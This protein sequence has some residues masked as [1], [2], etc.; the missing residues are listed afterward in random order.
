MGT[1]SFFV[2]ECVELSSYI[3]LIL[4]AHFVRR[5]LKGTSKSI[6]YQWIWNENLV[7]LPKSTS[8]ATPLTL[9]R[10]EE[11]TYFL[12]FQYGTANK[13][14]RLPAPLQYSSRLNNVAIGYVHLR[15]DQGDNEHTLRMSEVELVY[16]DAAGAGQILRR[17]KLERFVWTMPFHPHFSA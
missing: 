6:I 16:K 10:L 17:A 11:L 5:G 12:S 15:C 3:F 8:V 7:F 2:A 13:A 4:Y 1:F 9:A 14:P